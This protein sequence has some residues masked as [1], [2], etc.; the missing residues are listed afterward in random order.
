[1]ETILVCA[2]TA[3]P[4][5]YVLREYLDNVLNFKYPNFDLLLCDNTLDSGESTEHINGEIA[6]LTTDTKRFRAIHS[7]VSGIDS[8]IE[9]MA[10]SHND[11]RKAFL[12][13]NYSYML[14]LES[15]VLPP[16]TI[17]E[18][19][20]F[21]R[22]LVIGALYYRDEGSYRKLCIQTHVSRSPRN[23]FTVNMLPHEDALFI[24]GTVKRIASVGLGCVLI[25]RSVLEKIPFRFI[26]GNSSHPDSFFSEDCFKNGIDIF[27]DTNIIARHDNK[28]WGVHGFD[29][30]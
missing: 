4:K 27:A 11:C 8:V 5:S 13:G 24:D 6:K 19:L 3:Q 15:D 9:R 25:H 28:P 1:M 14:H 17:I 12:E 20:L 2:P 23:I 21:H 16:P 7:K 22:K 30:H 18:D 29:F 26:P 10:I